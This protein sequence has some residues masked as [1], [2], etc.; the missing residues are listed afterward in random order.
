MIL[1]AASVPA[2]GIKNKTAPVFRGCLI[3]L[4]HLQKHFQ[5]FGEPEISLFGIRFGNLAHIQPL[6]FK[7]IHHCQF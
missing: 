7:G 1:A 6:V 3:L 5:E 4:L 2:G